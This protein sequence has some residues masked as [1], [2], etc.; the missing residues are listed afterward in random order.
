VL[1]L[2]L[3]LDFTSCALCDQAEIV[4]QECARVDGAIV[5]RREASIAA[6]MAAPLVLVTGLDP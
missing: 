5:H 6:A 3:A 2:L 4:A 1:L